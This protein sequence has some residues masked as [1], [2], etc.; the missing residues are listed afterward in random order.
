MCT[1][2]TITK[3]SF[4]LA[5]MFHCLVPAR[6]QKDKRY[7]NTRTRV[8]RPCRHAPFRSM[9]CSCYTTLYIT[10][11][12]LPP[13][14]ALAADSLETRFHETIP[15]EVALVAST[16]STHANVQTSKSSRARVN[17][18]GFTVH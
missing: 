14:I 8:A 11:S 9:M 3:A 16:S 5:H 17:P 2:N 18:H 7:P 4:V 12:D 15:G 13:P 6:I 1:V 10:C